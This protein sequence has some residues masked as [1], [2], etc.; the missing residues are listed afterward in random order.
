MQFVH[1]EYNMDFRM[2][3][4]F[5]STIKTQLNVLWSFCQLDSRVTS[6]KIFKFTSYSKKLKILPFLMYIIFLNSIFFVMSTTLKRPNGNLACHWINRLAILLLRQ[7]NVTGERLCFGV[8]K[9][10]LKSGAWIFFSTF[11]CIFVYR[12]MQKMC[13]GNWWHFL[14]WH[15]YVP[16]GLIFQ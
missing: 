8:D 7:A 5:L 6:S 4:T 3:K 11:G 16:N 13:G 15:K 12:K 9:K 10:A 1:F 2:I 14:Y